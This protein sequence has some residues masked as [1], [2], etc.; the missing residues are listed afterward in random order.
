MTRIIIG[1]FSILIIIFLIL[2]L[3]QFDFIRIYKPENL[4]WIPIL[5]TIIAFYI[6]G[7][8]CRKVNL[9]YTTVLL[10]G[11]FLIYVPFDSLYF[12]YSIYIFLF[13][14]C[15]LVIT[16]KE[17][18]RKVKTLLI[19]A[20][21]II[22]GFLLFRQPL[23][24]KQKGFH[25]TKNGDLVNAKTIWNFNKVP[26]KKLPSETFLTIENKNFS[27]KV[28]KGKTIYLSFWATWCA[29]CI[30]EKPILDKLKREFKN[31]SEIVFID[32]S[33]DNDSEKWKNYLDVNKTE[34]IQ[35]ISRNSDKTRHNYQISGI[36]E[37]IAINAQGNFKSMYLLIAKDYLADTKKLNTFINSKLEVYERKK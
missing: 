26:S 31:N 3:F 27:L 37:H 15:T 6:A 9:K 36:P 33:L 16:R 22:F 32:I 29:P 25:F 11:L 34:G 4:K 20:V 12:P 30:A 35:L 19:S 28:L 18:N 17:I 1:L 21:L 7:T 5:I 2:V 14:I 24:I 13:A 23:I 8:I 10:L